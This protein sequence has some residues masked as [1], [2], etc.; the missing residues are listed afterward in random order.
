MQ[1]PTTVTSVERDSTTTTA[2]PRAK[3]VWTIV[4]LARIEGLV[5]SAFPTSQFLLPIELALAKVPNQRTYVLFA[6]LGNLF[7]MAHAGTVLTTALR[8]PHL[9]EFVKN[10]LTLHS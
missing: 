2:T 6:T 1:A 7:K 5:W 3:I 4:R 9:S 10:V 8:A